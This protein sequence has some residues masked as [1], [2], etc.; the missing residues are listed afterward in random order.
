MYG[1]TATL[2]GLAFYLVISYI[3]RIAESNSPNDDLCG[4]A[5]IS[6]E[7][8]QD[9][10]VF[11]SIIG[12]LVCVCYCICTIGANIY[13]ARMLRSVEHEQR[14]GLTDDDDIGLVDEDN[15]IEQEQERDSQKKS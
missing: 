2:V 8:C 1:F 4:N 14:F 9:I 15:Q 10:I 3:V 13:F 11:S 5:N 6:M 12:M 7:K